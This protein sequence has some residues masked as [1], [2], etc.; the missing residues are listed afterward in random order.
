[1]QAQC[2]RAIREKRAAESELEKITRHIPAEADRLTMTLEEM[3]SKLRASDRERNEANRK[4]ETLHQKMIRDQNV[5][6]SERFQLY[7]RAE[8]AFR[9]LK[10]I[11]SEEEVRCSERLDLI[12]KISNLENACK[13]LSEEKHKATLLQE[14]NSSALVQKYE[15]KITDLNSKLE[16]VSEAH[17]RTCTEMQQLLSDQRRLSEKWHRIINF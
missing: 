14:S 16:I 4:L 17:S 11:E 2:E 12:N 6:E 8:E 13:T 1:M 3:H 7:D 15:A 5:F 10:R 9:R